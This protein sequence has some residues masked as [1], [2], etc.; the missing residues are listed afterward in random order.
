MTLRARLL[1][2]VTLLVVMVAPLPVLV[3]VAHAVDVWTVGIN[4]TRQGWNKFETVLTPANVPGLR[5]IREF[6]VDEKVDTTPLVVGDKLFVFTMKSTAYIFD[7]NTGARLAKRQLVAPFD[8]CIQPGQMDMWC[9]YRSWGISQTPVIDVATNTIYATTFGKPNAG[10][11]NTDVTTC[12]G[13][14]TPT[15][16]PIKSRQCLLLAML[17]TAA[18][19]SRMA[20]RHRTRK[21]ARG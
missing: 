12:S 6:E 10:S 1:A 9:V 14:S 5:K 20:L 18:A 11:E 13:Y 2:P 19:G 4:N 7:V 3:P 15:H 8:P 17:T 21:C 16:S